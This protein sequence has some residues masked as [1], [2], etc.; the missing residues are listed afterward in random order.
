M[1]IK[2]RCTLCGATAE[3]KGRRVKCHNCSK[4][5]LIPLESTETTVSE[6][7]K[8]NKVRG[9]KIFK[10]NTFVDDGTQCL[11]DKEFTKK[12][13]FSVSQRETRKS[14]KVKKQCSLCQKEFIAYHD[15]ER[16]C[17]KCCRG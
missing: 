2:Y 6:N 5:S 9:E 14:E 13:K 16:R 4:M 11:K 12:V 1:L 10:G 7:I 8:P 3:F 17:V 15:G